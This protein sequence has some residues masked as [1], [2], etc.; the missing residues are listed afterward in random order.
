MNQIKVTRKF[1]IICEQC[2]FVKI[3]KADDLYKYECPCGQ[4]KTVRITER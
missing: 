1:D 3:V 2:G 4:G